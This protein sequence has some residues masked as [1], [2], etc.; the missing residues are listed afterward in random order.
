MDDLISLAQLLQEF[1]EL[2]SQL[3]RWYWWQQVTSPGDNVN[4]CRNEVAE[5]SAG[6]AATRMVSCKF[7][8]ACRNEVAQGRWS[9]AARR[10]KD[11]LD[12]PD[13]LSFIP[14]SYEQAHNRFI[15]RLYLEYTHTAI[16]WGLVREPERPVDLLRALAGHPGLPPSQVI[17]LLDHLCRKP[18]RQ[19]TANVMLPVLVLEHPGEPG[20]LGGRGVVLKLCL[21]RLAPG[22]GAL[23]PHP[24]IA[25]IFLDAAF[26]KAMENA[27]QT[28]ARL[29]LWPVDHDVRWA[30]SRSDGHRLLALSGPSAGA[31][32]A[33][34]IAKLFA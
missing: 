6:V 31:A 22:D 18:L 32:F 21:D 30:V 12:H 24:G 34:G 4:S 11:L 26:V 20:A 14:D 16:S 17:D 7:V 27:R 9:E 28:V 19:A 33:L 2:S 1:E 15:A 8:N 29:G 25:F 13:S 23:Y 3:L 10:W 5:P